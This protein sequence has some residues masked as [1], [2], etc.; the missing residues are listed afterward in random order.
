VRGGPPPP[1]PPSYLHES[2][3]QGGLS[4]THS[5]PLTARVKGYDECDPLATGWHLARLFVWLRQTI[6]GMGKQSSELQIV[7]CW[8]EPFL[9]EWLEGDPPAPFSHRNHANHQYCKVIGHLSVTLRRGSATYVLVGGIGGEGEIC[10]QS[11]TGRRLPT[12]YVAVWAFGGSVSGIP[13]TPET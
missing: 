13:P 10:S 4:V 1:P 7:A 2:E 11:T 5:E 9:L 8:Y 6:Q 12:G 3:R